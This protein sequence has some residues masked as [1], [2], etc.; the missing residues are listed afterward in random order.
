M[1]GGTGGNSS[2]YGG[3]GGGGGYNGGGG[4]GS[5]VAGGRAGGGGGGASFFANSAAGTVGPVQFAVGGMVKISWGFSQCPAG[6]YSANGY[7]YPS[8]CTPA[9]KGHYATGPGATSQTPCAAG[10]FA[11]TT[12][13]TQC[14]PATKG[15][16][17][18]QP[19]S[20]HDA[21]CAL[22]FYQP[23][24]GATACLLAD[25]GYYVDT[26]GADHQTA[27]PAGKTTSSTA[28]DSASDCVPFT[29]YQVKQNAAAH[30]QAL[31]PTGSTANDSLLNRAIV[32]INKSLV[33]W[34]WIGQDAL[35]PLHG[36]AVFTHERRAVGLLMDP[37]FA[38]NATVSQA[39]H[40]LLAADRAIVV[41]AIDDDTDLAERTSANAQLARAD[42]FVAA[43]R[44]SKAIHALRR[45]WLMVL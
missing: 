8:S 29:P 11:A 35:T 25:I 37:A 21:P 24:T 23:S 33:A 12:A 9:D 45:A 38:G 17:V 10:F 39:I 30:L 20:D 31:L 4:G 7:D 19:A 34:R 27:C 3:G 14:D 1:S 22:G 18:D 16:Y 13:Q 41:K 40:D 15:H 2:D 44:Y 42:G 6:F 5:A 26:T 28:S 32:R 36:W 43:G